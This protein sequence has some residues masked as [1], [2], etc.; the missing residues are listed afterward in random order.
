LDSGRTG[1]EEITVLQPWILYFHKLLLSHK[2]K[3]NSIVPENKTPVP[4]Q[5]DIAS[6]SSWL[7][8]YVTPKTANKKQVEVEAFASHP[9]VPVEIPVP[10]FTGQAFPSDWI[11]NPMCMFCKANFPMMQFEFTAGER[12]DISFHVPAT[13]ARLPQ[14]LR[15]KLGPW[16]CPW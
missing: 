12:K 16:K 5:P 1:D 11:L 15:G 2:R 10:D 8:H 14:L 7:I 9:L 4:S 13:S 6:K 3:Y